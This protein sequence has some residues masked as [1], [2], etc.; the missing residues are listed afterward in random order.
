MYSNHFV[1]CVLVNGQPTQ[2]LANGVVS[3]PFGTEYALRFRNKNDRRAVVKIFIDGENVSGG[4]YIVGAN[5]HVDIKRH[6]DKDRSFK[7][8]SL[9][10][11]DAVDFGKNGPNTDKVKGTIEAR[12]YLEKKQPPQPVYVPV[13]HD[14]HH[15]HHYPQ[16]YPQP[17]PI[18]PQVWCTNMGGGGTTSS[19]GGVG[20]SSAG[21]PRN[22]RSRSFSKGTS[23][24]NAT[25]A[26][27]GGASDFQTD[28]SFNSGLEATTYGCAVP[29]ASDNEVLK[30]G[31]T[32]EGYSTGQNFHTVY[33]DTEDTYTS[34]KLF[35][36]GYSGND[37]SNFV[38]VPEKPRKTNKSQRV[39]DLEAEN[40]KLRLKLAEIENEKLKDL[41]DKKLK[42]IDELNADKPKPKRK[43][44]SRKSVE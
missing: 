38:A 16:P 19:L 18:R 22:T 21:R 14:H 43:P 10:S 36:Q 17:Y 20:G 41:V 27:L 26:G 29:P 28:A 15:H 32:V 30:D 31:C 8:V 2:E 23:E 7:F 42:R 1:M 3:L 6:H 13:I 9:D 40:E 11:A 39:D 24:W 35:L 33:I 25:V 34:L 5:D 37:S 12:F 44:R 4:G